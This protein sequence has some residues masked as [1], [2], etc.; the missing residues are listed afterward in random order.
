MLCSVVL[1]VAAFREWHSRLSAR[2]FRCHAHGRSRPPRAD[3][4]FPSPD[5]DATP[6][7]RRRRRRHAEERAMPPPF[8]Q[9]VSLRRRCRCRTPTPDNAAQCFRTRRRH[10]SPTLREAF[11][12]LFTS[13]HVLIPT[14][15]Q[16]F[17]A[18]TLT[19]PFR[20]SRR[21]VSPV[22]AHARRPI[23]AN[24]KRERRHRV[25][26]PLTYEKKR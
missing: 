16:R 7:P 10:A 24:R 18:A 13:P 20:L 5:A 1:H 26:R 11:T 21:A 3:A 9:L 8:A 4:H 22:A 6:P 17:A 25:P 12:P 2:V 23:H 19:S 15:S 14:Q